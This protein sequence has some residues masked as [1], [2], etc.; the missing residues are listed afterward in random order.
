ML[1]LLVKTGTEATLIAFVGR[2]KKSAAAPPSTI[3]CC[4]DFNSH[5]AEADA[6]CHS[7]LEGVTLDSP[8]K[9]KESN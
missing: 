6:E 5:E 2:K 9:K 3:Y 7:S 8:V 1:G 4:Q